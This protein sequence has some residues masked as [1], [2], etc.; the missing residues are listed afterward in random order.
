M[1]IRD[2]TYKC[3][4]DF[5]V[6]IVYAHLR[7]QNILINILRAIIWP[8]N[9]G[10]IDTICVHRVGQIGDIVCALP[11]IYL[12]H[13]KWP[14]SKIIV[15]TS[16]GFLKASPFVDL[17]K[18][19]PWIS[20]IETYDSLSVK[21]SKIFLDL[22][23][24]LRNYKIDLW[25]ALPQDLTNISTEVRNML[26]AKIIGAGYGIGFGVNTSKLFS[27]Y[28]LQFGSFKHETDTLLDIVEPLRLRDKKKEYGFEFSL[29]DNSHLPLEFSSNPG[30]I[31]VMAPGANRKANRWPI[32][33]FASIASRWFLS[34]GI[35]AVVGGPQDRI[36]GEEI[37]KFIDSKSFI[38]L[39]GE[40]NLAETICLLSKSKVLV[41][42]DSG[43]MH[44]A[45]VAKT[46][47]VAIFSARDFPLK[48]SPCP[49]LNKV[50]RVNTDCSPCFKDE[51][52]RDNLCL[53]LVAVDDVWKGVKNIVQTCN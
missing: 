40:T 38:N 5:I 49:N 18:G 12:L 4:G 22:V 17:K 44:L 16:A 46:P 1:M 28:Q 23:K 50:L 31:M 21:N 45:S 33:R 8:A 34:G 9:R 35:I 48:W 2:K 37:K 51:C 10:V 15:L 19:I 25:V 13:Q 20:A 36:L 32:D 7:I 24:C 14:Q 3:F 53:S 11:A 52:N 47:A 42:N 27:G 6:S 30:K 39:C 26:F 41:T 29:V 43:P